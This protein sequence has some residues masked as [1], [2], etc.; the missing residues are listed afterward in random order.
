MSWK[1]EARPYSYK[2]YEHEVVLQQKKIANQNIVSNIVFVL[3]VQYF[4]FVYENCTR[5]FNDRRA[6]SAQTKERKIGSYSFSTKTY[7]IM[8]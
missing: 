1:F 3:I 5:K 7:N 6:G 4:K 2:T 8:E